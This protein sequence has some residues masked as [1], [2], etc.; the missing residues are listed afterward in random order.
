MAGGDRCG[1]VDVSMTSTCGGAVK[2]RPKKVE[3]AVKVHDGVG[4]SDVERESVVEYDTFVDFV[5]GGACVR[6]EWC[7]LDYEA[8]GLR[9]YRLD[10][11]G[12]VD[13]FE[14]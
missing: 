12:V 7:R 6:D 3:C 13:S 8:L 1:G 10:W 5:C 11:V 4:A 14:N 2:R 9:V